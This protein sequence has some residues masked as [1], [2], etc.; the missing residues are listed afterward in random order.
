M[1]LDPRAGE[2]GADRQADPRRT[3]HQAETEAAGRER[4]SRQKR[5]AD[6]DEG[7][8]EHAHVPSDQDRQQRARAANE[9]QAVGQVAPVASA[10]RPGLLQQ[11][12][13]DL[14]DQGRRD[15]K[16][17]RVDPVGEIRAL[18][19]DE[20]TAEERADRPGRVV[21]HLQQRV[22][23]RQVLVADEI[24]QPGIHSGAEKAGRDADHR[25]KADDRG[26][27]RGEGQDAEH[28]EA[29][30]IG[31]D[32]Q[33]AAGETVDERG[34]DQSDEQRRQDVGDQQRAHPH[35]RMGPHEHVDLQCDE[36]EPGSEPGAEG[37]QEERAEARLSAEEPESAAGHVAA[38]GSQKVT[39]CCR[40][41]RG[42][43]WTRR[44]WRPWSAR[45]PVPRRGT[46]FPRRCRRSRGSRSVPRSRARAE[47]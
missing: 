42:V 24:R 35:R 5:L 44:F 27:V 7:V 11:A 13:R 32:Q 39:G 23:L 22:G 21:D 6:V 4:I 2:V 47:R 25:R 17:D 14:R 34:R 19:G 41:E 46:C 10:L 30:E 37:G 36:G 45:G 43:F 9:R 38:H 3:H 1:L 8:G 15:H 16:G 29:D 20:R 28:A 26:C 40:L 33:G 18:R 31:A 12:L